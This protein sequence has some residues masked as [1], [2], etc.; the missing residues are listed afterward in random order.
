MMLEPKKTAQ[1][2]LNLHANQDDQRNLQFRIPR[3]H[4]LIYLQALNGSQL[5][6][7]IEDEDWNA[8]GQD[9]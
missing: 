1:L 4:N 8:F 7:G 5:S 9:L 3:L 6:L 2:K